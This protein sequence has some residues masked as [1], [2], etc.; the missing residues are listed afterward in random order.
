[1][2][3]TTRQ[4][5]ATTTA[6]VV[7]FISSGILLFLDASP[8]RAQLAPPAVSMHGTAVQDLPLSPAEAGYHVRARR[9][10][11]ITPLGFDYLSFPRDSIQHEVAAAAAQWLVEAQRTPIR[12]IQLDPSGR[13]GIVANQV[14]YAQRQFAERLATPGLSAAAKA[15]TL[16]AA[17]QAFADPAFPE[18][19]PIAEHYLAQLNALGDTVAI[20]RWLGEQALVQAYYLLG[21][22]DDVVRHG[23]HAIE[24]LPTIPYQDRLI[25][26]YPNGIHDLYIPTVDALTGQPGGQAKIDRL[27]TILRQEVKAPSAIVALDSEYLDH[28]RASENELSIYL[29]GSALLGTKGAPIV[30]NYWL[31]RPTR[32]SATVPVDDGRIHVLLFASYNCPGCITVSYTLQRLKRQF[33]D[34]EPTS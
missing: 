31:N 28:Q 4:S 33:P 19:L 29:R 2:I 20:Y 1:M 5:Y 34:I 17:L 11:L 30:S 26:V 8:A 7:A 9:S 25:A 13:I 23:V 6:A 21:R 12:G 15:Y 14:Q 3:M 18:R 32:D 22:S 24:Q 10:R 16:V 27:N